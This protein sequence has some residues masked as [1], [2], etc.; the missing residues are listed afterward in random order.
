[1]NVFAVYCVAAVLSRASAIGPIGSFGIGNLGKVPKCEPS[2]TTT[3]GTYGTHTGTYCSGDV[4]FEDTFDKLDLKKW[5]HENTLA[6]GGNFEFQWY[7]NNRSIS[8]CDEGHLFIKPALTSDAFGETYLTHGSLNLHGRSP[9]DYCSDPSFFGCERTGTHQ[10]IL[11]PIRS[12][13]LRTV[14]SFS[15]KYGKVEINAKL[16]SGDWLWSG[17]GLMPRDNSYGAWPSSG[18]ISLVGSR[19]N[20]EL[21]QNG[22]NIGSEQIQST[23]HFG[24]FPTQHISTNFPRNS[25]TGNAWSNDFHRYQMEWSP[26]K[27][28]FSVDDVEIGAVIA[29]AG[30]W[31]RGNFDINAPGLQNPWIQSTKM[32]P[33]DQEFYIVLNLAVCG[34]SNF[35][36]DSVN[37][38][39]KPWMNTSPTSMTSFWE[40]KNQ[41]LPTWNVE[42]SDAAFVIDYV[43]VRAL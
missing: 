23:V 12:A 16:P 24:P 5:E 43:R 33:F 2:P 13:S 30:F 21:I 37:P 31:D 28:I 8:F 39:G 25:P 27:L 42:N 10:N 35:P 15:F 19:G 36:D 41:W 38:G 14:N 7:T 4:I 40:G 32:A 9:A 17:I 3:S 20:K 1:M 34:N 29:N 6:G 11:N 18:E 22:I 26:E